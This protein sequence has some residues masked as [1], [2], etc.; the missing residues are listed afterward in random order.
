MVCRVVRPVSAFDRCAC[1][2]DL[3]YPRGT[4]DMKLE[5][6]SRISVSLWGTATGNQGFISNAGVIAGAEGITI[7]DVPDSP[8]LAEPMW[9]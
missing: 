7:V 4:V 2:F 6:A 5:K 8:S 9:L 3:K 1:S